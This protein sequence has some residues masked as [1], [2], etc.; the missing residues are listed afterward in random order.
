MSFRGPEVAVW[1]L[2]AG[3]GGARDIIVS[4]QREG[5]WEIYMRVPLLCASEGV[6]FAVCKEKEQI[7]GAEREMHF[8]N[9]TLPSHPFCLGKE[10][11]ENKRKL[12]EKKKEKKTSWLM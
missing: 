3:G 1:T 11:C 2:D 5:M 7:D 4:G 6:G 8:S 10:Q 12:L 9:V